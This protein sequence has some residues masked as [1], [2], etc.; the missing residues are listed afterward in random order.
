[1]RLEYCRESFFCNVCFKFTVLSI[2]LL[3]NFF[4]KRK[5]DPLQSMEFSGFKKKS[6]VQD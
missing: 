5:A 2:D 6:K 3:N 4:Q 1:M